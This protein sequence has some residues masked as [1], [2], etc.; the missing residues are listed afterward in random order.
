MNVLLIT[1]LDNTLYN[2]VDYFGM[3]FRGMTH[4]I[5]REMKIDE[6]EFIQGAK[7]VF[8]KAGTLEYAFLIQELPFISRY[9]EEQLKSFIEI[10][11]TVF[12]I[13]KSKNLIPYDGV[14]ETF[15]YLNSVGVTI[16]A[17][18]NAPIY[19]GEWRLKELGIAKYIHGILGWEGLEVPKDKH[20]EHIRRNIYE[21][22]Y[23]SKHIKYRWA[24]PKENIKPNPVGYLKIISQLMVSHKNTYILGD[25]LGKDIAPAIE[26]GAHSIWAKYGTVFEKKNLDTLI[27]ITHWED[28]Q[29]K[30]EYAK[31]D[32]VP[33]FIINDISEL[34]QIIQGPQLNLFKE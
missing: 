3:S 14:I 6:I 2:W 27:N 17:V 24:E 12:Q 34:R 23:K 30:E 4:A 7:Q 26:I 21:G 11:K 29:V 18:T 13:V 9:D 25:S 28:S 5:A 10:S 8:K 32:I 15:K 22:I 16:V 33:E 31:K 20:T 19:Y 1:D